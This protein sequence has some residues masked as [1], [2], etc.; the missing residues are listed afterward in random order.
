MNYE[1]NGMMLGFALNAE[2]LKV[3]EPANYQ[4]DT[5]KQ[6]VEGSKVTYSADPE[7]KPNIIFVMSEAF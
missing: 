5:I 7:F 2:Y 6:V 3:S 4:E 1:E